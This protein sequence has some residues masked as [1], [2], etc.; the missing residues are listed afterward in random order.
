MHSTSVATPATATRDVF[1]VDFPRFADP[2]D[3]GFDDRDPTSFE[4]QRFSCRLKMQH[5]VLLF[6]LCVALIVK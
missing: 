4:Y 3:G 2:P 5:Q 6:S 1:T